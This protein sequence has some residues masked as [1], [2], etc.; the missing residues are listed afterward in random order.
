MLLLESV[1][2]DRKV[3]VTSAVLAKH[4]KHRH[5]TPWMPNWSSSYISVASDCGHALLLLSVIPDI[6]KILGERNMPIS[7]DSK[8]CCYVVGGYNVQ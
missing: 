8:A 4:S 2:D 7:P 6:S 5:D 1:E 3:L